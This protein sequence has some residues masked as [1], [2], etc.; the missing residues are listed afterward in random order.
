MTGPQLAPGVRRRCPALSIESATRCG[1]SRANR[2]HGMHRAPH[3]D[4]ALGLAARSAPPNAEQQ[5]A[6]EALGLASRRSRAARTRHLFVAI[7]SNKM[8]WGW[9][10]ISRP[11]PH[12]GCPV[13]APVGGQ[14]ASAN[15]G[16]ARAV[17]RALRELPV[18]C[19]KIAKFETGQPGCRPPAPTGSFTCR[20]CSTRGGP[21]GF[22]RTP[23]KI[24]GRGR[25]PG[26]SRWRVGGRR[27]SGP[28]RRPLVGP[29]RFSEHRLPLLA[30][31]SG[32]GTPSN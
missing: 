20:R 5:N 31:V 8:D 25:R 13:H 17:P 4:E 9:V 3:R 21:I 16:F 1:Q 26:N 19:Q 12:R 29:R 24:R 32:S 6:V 15:R 10:S 11:G 23:R 27:I 28:E 2:A 18:E 30:Q 22:M 14:H 7:G